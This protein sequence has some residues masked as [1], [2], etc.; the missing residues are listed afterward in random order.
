M[1]FVADPDGEGDIQMA[2][3]AVFAAHDLKHGILH[4]A[5]LGT[6]KNLGM[7]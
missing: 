7:A 2:G 5:F 4:R 1:A 6:G 3:A